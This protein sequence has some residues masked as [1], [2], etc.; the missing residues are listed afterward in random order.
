MIVACKDKLSVE[1]CTQITKTNFLKN[2][3]LKQE[4]IFEVSDSST[5]IELSKCKQTDRSSLSS[6]LSLSSSFDMCAWPIGGLDVEEW[7]EEKTKKNDD[8]K[9]NINSKI[10]DA[11][12][13]WNWWLDNVAMHGFE[14]VG[15]I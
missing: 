7:K 8:S 6:S 13:R 1:R 12:E 14:S 11:K 3:F 5:L 2:Q 10:N 4:D 9:L 15:V